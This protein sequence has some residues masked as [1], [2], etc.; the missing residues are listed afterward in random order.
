M[1]DNPTSPA[2]VGERDDALWKEIAETVERE[3]LPF[4]SIRASA[5]LIGDAVAEVVLAALRAAPSER[6]RELLGAIA[7]EH[8]LYMNSRSLGYVCPCAYCKDFRALGIGP[9]EP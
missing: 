1:T 8:A 5:R 4:V 3:V 6:E 9:Q 2:A 7:H